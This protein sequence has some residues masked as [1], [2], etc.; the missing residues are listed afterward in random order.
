ME[1]TQSQ[2]A[3]LYCALPFPMNPFKPKSPRFAAGSNVLRLG[4]PLKGAAAQGGQHGAQQGGQQG[5]QHGAQQ[6]GQHGAAASS[7]VPGAP[8]YETLSAHSAQE[9]HAQVPS[10]VSVDELYAKIHRKDLS[11][12]RDAFDRYHDL[13]HRLLV[14]AL[15]PG[16]DIEELLDDVFLSFFQ[17]ASRIQ[18]SEK[19]RSY[20]V[21]ITMNRLRA[22]IRRRKRAELW[23]RFTGASGE[24]DA[25]PGTDDPKAKAALIQLSRI[26]DE[27]SAEERAT[28]LLRSLE[29]MPFAEIAEALSISESTAHRRAKR[30][31][32]H[33][34][35]KVAR[36]ALLCDYI[37]ADYF[38]DHAREKGSNS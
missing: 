37:R 25:N 15:G 38:R 32:E 33:V 5:G 22:E 8:G 16:A 9:A 36:N 27:L 24:P 31:T 28:F 1:A 29:G 10:V 23:Q 12:Q 7:S 26:L 34:M 30:A 13:V 4:A 21:S 17:H 35:K 20:L 14:R 18:S 11:W 6:G 19:V 2:A 3:K